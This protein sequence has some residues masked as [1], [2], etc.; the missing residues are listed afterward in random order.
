MSGAWPRCQASS[1]AS[2]RSRSDT[3]EVLG[4]C[5]TG[6]AE[7]MGR[8]PRASPSAPRRLAAQQAVKGQQAGRLPGAFDLFLAAPVGG[9][10]FAPAL[11]VGVAGLDRNRVVRIDGE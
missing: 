10:E 4:G 2:M 3:G 9:L 11:R 6:S 5:G 8:T 7:D 1:N